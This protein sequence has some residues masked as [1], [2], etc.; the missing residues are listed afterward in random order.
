M[1]AYVCASI[2]SLLCM[3][4]RVFNAGLRRVRRTSTRMSSGLRCALAAGSAAASACCSV[5]IS[6]WLCSGTTLGAHTHEG[7]CVGRR[8]NGR[9]RGGLER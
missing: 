7:V 6:L 1:R 4:A 8:V 3:C 5:L 9:E 2:E